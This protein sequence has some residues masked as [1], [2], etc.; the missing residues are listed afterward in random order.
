MYTSAQAFDAFLRSL[1]PTEKQAAEATR[2]EQIMSENLRQALRPRQA[3]LS[4]SYGRGTAIRPLHDI[5]IFLILGAETVP[6]SAPALSYLQRIQKAL[7]ASYPGKQ[8]RI[9]ARSVNIEFA[10]TEIGFDVVPALEDPSQP[11]IYFIPERDSGSWIRSNP[12]LHKQACN[13]ADTR[14]SNMLRPLIKLVKRWNQR[15]NKLLASFHLEVMA[16]EAFSSRPASYAQGL[17]RLFEFLS[18]RVATSCPEPAGLGPDIDARLTPTVREEA[19]RNLAAAGRKAAKALE[20]EQHGR[21][22]DAYPLWRA[23]LGDDFP[24]R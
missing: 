2:Q 8:A 20:Y 19:R 10:G 6:P 23:L 22:A 11:G 15:H 14:A 17:Q 12:R 4:G 24:S 18:E 3:I 21:L 1:E 5:D 9:Q 13:Q 7:V 16:Y